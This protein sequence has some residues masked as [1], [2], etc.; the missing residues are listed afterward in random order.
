MEGR[1]QAILRH[2]VDG[3]PGSSHIQGEIKL[4]ES[5]IGTGHRPAMRCCMMGMALAASVAGRVSAQAPSIRI[6]PEN[7]R[8]SSYLRDLAGPRALAGI[9]GGGMLQQLRQ[10]DGTSLEERLASRAAQHV[11]EVSVRDG[12]AA[13]MHRSTDYG[14]QFCE[15][16]GFGPRVQHALLEDLHRSPGRREPG[17]LGP[18]YRWN[19]R[20]RLRRPRLEARPQRGRRG[21]GGHP[22]PGLLGAVQHRPRVERR[23]PLAGATPPHRPPVIGR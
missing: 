20:R 23:G 17:A 16:R 9:A 15:C 13:L 21:G 3:R 6:T 14:Y 1:R 12:L 4:A 18:P 19:L 7:V 10:N 2:L 22:F 8:F 11:A 5:R